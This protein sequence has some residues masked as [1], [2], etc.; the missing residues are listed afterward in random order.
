[1]FAN[2]LNWFWEIT[3]IDALWD[4]LVLNVVGQIFEWLGVSFPF[5]T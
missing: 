1:M 3:G 5:L 2:L 4:Q